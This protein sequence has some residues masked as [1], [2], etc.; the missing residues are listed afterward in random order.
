MSCHIVF[1]FPTTHAYCTE[2]RFDLMRAKLRNTWENLKATLWFEPS[3]LVAAAII[4]SGITLSLDSWL[5]TRDSGLR[6]WLFGGTPD[7]AQALLTMIAG[8][9]VT[10]VSIAFSITIVA[11]Q[12]ASTQFSPR[13]LRTTL[14]DD[15]GNHL[16][17]GASIATFVYS[18]LILRQT[19]D[20]T[21]TDAGYVPV[22]SIT[23]VLGLALVCL[24]LLIYF[25][26]HISE[27]LQVAVI[28]D[29]VHT[30]TIKELD[31]CYPTT[32]GSLTLDPPPIITL[33]DLAKH[34]VA[35]GGHLCSKHSGFLRS[36]DHPSFF[37]ATDGTATW[38]WVRPCVGE[39]VARGSVLIEWAQDRQID[40]MRLEQA[41][42]AFVLDR[43]RSL[44][45]DPLFGIRQL[46]DIALKA[47]SPAIN[48]P[49]TAEYCLSSL[50][51]IIGRLA[52][53][54]FASCEQTGSGGHT[55]YFF[56]TP[57]WDDFVDAAF[58]QIRRQ[59]AGDV[60]VT[61]YLLG[62]LQTL[63]QHIPAGPRIDPV[64]YQVDE[65]RRVL[66]TG[67]FSPA[68]TRSLRRQ[69]EQ[70]EQAQSTLAHMAGFG[71]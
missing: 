60:H 50:G 39:Y 35:A 31:T 32:D 12:L 17:L 11:I 61:G 20:D 62:V 49:T 46:A 15:R 34:D 45:Q 27:L 41:E 42:S 37:E 38:L 7:A 54:P 13:V 2:K 18:L 68:D 56:S 19:R 63:I 48:D 57:T 52:Q 65:I 59:A 64:Q 16:V 44:Y 47:L 51:D 21:A 4:L 23:L 29:R 10:S 25:I 30:E 43:E 67:I 71:T 28:I 66:D 40:A 22:L 24:A 6:S 58:S 26:H 8:T 9:L 5:V 53:R 70:V 1:R 55:R 14:T 36:I 33:V 69:C 3:L